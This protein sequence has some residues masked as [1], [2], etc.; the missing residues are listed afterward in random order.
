MG[1]TYSCAVGFVSNAMQKYGLDIFNFGPR[2]TEVIYESQKALSTV[3]ESCRYE[4]YCKGSRN[5][6]SILPISN[7]GVRPFLLSTFLNN[8]SRSHSAIGIEM[9]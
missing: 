4:N 6:H 2:Q 7:T 1:D 8:K 3:S 5:R 9:I